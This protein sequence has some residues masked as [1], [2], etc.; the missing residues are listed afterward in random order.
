MVKFFHQ[1]F[2]NFPYLEEDTFYLDRPLS[3]HE[4]IEIQPQL[5]QNYPTPDNNAFYSNSENES[6]VNSVSHENS[7]STEATP[8]LR[9]ELTS[10]IS[11]MQTD[12]EE[13]I[14]LEPS[15]SQ[16]THNNFDCLL[17]PDMKSKGRK[18]RSNFVRMEEQKWNEDQL[19][20]AETKTRECLHDSDSFETSITPTESGFEVKTK[21]KDRISNSI[22]KMFELIS[23]QKRRKPRVRLCKGS[24]AFQQQK[25][26][27]TKNYSKVVG[28]KF[29]DYVHQ[30]TNK[31]IKTYFKDRISW[32]SLKKILISGLPDHGI[33]ANT[34]QVFLL[35]FIK[36]LDGLLFKETK[37]QSPISKLC[38]TI[39][40]RMLNLA[41]IE[42]EKV[43]E[44]SEKLKSSMI[45][46]EKSWPEVIISLV[47]EEPAANRN[48]RN[49][50]NHA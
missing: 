46:I 38:Y 4:R 40:N 26:N 6:S 45:L 14:Y 13:E 16:T 41:V 39:M 25:F 2:L 22:D 31:P 12:S 20:K 24:K 1:I 23:N 50:A 3:Q 15:D 37:V 33:P 30:Q 27:L 44:S 34:L 18:K 7:A 42:I 5:P 21:M 17:T 48:T 9:P 8:I 32:K 19:E 35:S 43:Q 47:K 36:E 29:G 28:D 10:K 49:G 11:S